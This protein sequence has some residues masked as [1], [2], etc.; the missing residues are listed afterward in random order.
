MKEIQQINQNSFKTLNR[1]FERFNDN[2]SVILAHC[3]HG[4]VKERI[5]KQLQHQHPNL[6]KSV[7]LDSEVINVYNALVQVIDAEPIP[8][9][10]LMISGLESNEQLDLLIKIMNQMREEFRRRFRCPLVFWVT[11]SLLHALIRLAP[12]FYSWSTALKFEISTEDLLNFIQETADQVSAKVLDSGAGIFLNNSYF[13]LEL[14][15]PLRFE[16]EAAYQELQKRGEPLNIELEASLEFVLGRVSEHSD[17]VA[18]KHYERSLELWQQTNNLIRY[19]QL[20]FYIGFWWHSYGILHRAEKEYAYEQA[21]S[22]YTQSIQ[23]FKR[24]NRWDLVAKFINALADVLFGLKKWQELETVAKESIYYNRIYTYPFREAR[25]YHFLAEVYLAKSCWQE[26]KNLAEKAQNLLV[27]TASNY[28]PKTSD[29]Q[30]ILDWETSYHQGWYLVAL[31]QANQKLKQSQDAIKILEKAQARTK[32]QY[33]PDL[34]IQILQLLHDFYFEKREYLK[35]YEIKQKRRE[36]EQQFRLRAF[37]GAGR[38]GH[39]QTISNP[40]LPPMKNEKIINPEITASGRLSVVNWLYERISRNDCKLTVIYGQSGVGKSSILQAG[41]IPELRKA[42]LDTR[43]FI[44]VLLQVYTNLNQDFSRAFTK[45]IRE[46]KNIDLDSSE[47]NSQAVI[48]EQIRSLVNQNFWV[49]II[50]DQFEEFFFACKDQQQRQSCY[51]FIKECLDIPYVKVVLSLREDYIQYLLECTRQGY[52]EII[53]NNILDR[54]ILAYIGNFTREEA[55]SVIQSLTERTQFVLES[56]LIEELVED[57]AEDSGDIRPIELQVVGSQLQAQR[58]TTL[59]QY[60]QAGRKQKLV[61]DYLDEVIRDCGSTNKSLAELVLYLLTD[62]NNTRPLKTR[63]DLVREIKELANHFE[64]INENLDTVLKIFVLSGLVFILPEIPAERY[65]LVHDYLV[66]L[67]RQNRSL[68]ILEELDIERKKRKQAE[69]KNK[70]LWQLFIR[71]IIIGSGMALLFTLALGFWRISEGKNKQVNLALENTKYTALTTENNQLEALLT[72][73]TAGKLLSPQRPKSAIEQ[74]TQSKLSL[75]VQVI[76]EQNILDGHQKNS[77]LSVSI[78]PDNQLIASA[79]DDKTI[80][81]W[82]PKGKC[83]KTLEG[84]QKSVWF[85]TFSPNSQI[86][87]SASKD[88][89]IKLWTKNGILIRTLQGHTDEVKWVSFSP[90]GQ[91]IASASKDKTVKIWSLDGRLIQTL[92]G[93]QKP[94]LSVVFSPDGQEIASSSEDGI[95]NLWTRQGKLIKTIKAHSKSIWSIS[96]SPDSQI[97]ASASDDKTV[98]LWNRD[99]Q[100]IR[101]LEGHQQAVNSVAFSQDSRLIATG[102]TD[103]MIKIWTKEGSLISTLQGH[104]D[105]IN[106]VSFS[107]QEERLFSASKDGTVRIW[108]LKT[109]PKIIQ[110]KDYKIYSSSFSRQNSNLVASPGRDLRIKDNTK[111][112]VVVLW[113]LNGEVQKIFRGH[114]DTVNNVSFSPDGKSIASASQDKTVR[115][116]SVDSEKFITLPH[117][118]PV[119]SVVFSPD[120]QLIATASDDQSIKI[121]DIHGTLKQTFKGHQG[122]INDLSFSPDSQILASASEDK[123]VKLWDV[124]HKNLIPPLTGAQ[125]R[126]N[127]VSF[128]PDGQWIAA[129]KDGESIA[130]W[131]KQNSA[132]K[133]LQTS[134]VLGKHWK[135]IYEV[136]FSPN[137]KILA[138]AS[139]D[140]TIKL[141]DVNGSLIT[142]LKPSLEPILSVNFSPDG[143]TLVGLQKS[144]PS[145]I[146]IWKIDTNQINQDTDSLLTQACIQLKDYLETNPNISGKNKNICDDFKSSP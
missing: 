31:A 83:I 64:N 129:S 65:Q 100:L 58:I 87:A 111:D 29:E 66:S 79:S 8:P 142:T 47:L 12:D 70:E 91:E 77:V 136:N 19:G 104:K 2:F 61:E 28:H 72:L 96:F 11:D 30:L 134:V 17:Q 39:I 139:A 27:Q 81:I 126:F 1:I 133:P 121:W 48:L 107:K 76:Q 26:A 93:H 88:N 69:A 105:S 21:N 145:R 49:V 52:L 97:M 116:W 24:A 127:S 90:D 71:S 43:R 14:G 110:L 138:S 86:I 57:L 102:S 141:W 99:G 60:Q 109:L 38:L 56:A 67:I 5:I 89:T 98:K 85:V 135:A 41:F 20:L 25:G 4:I 95:I 54:N 75:A 94:V 73:V 113:T 16:L 131:K 82:T 13:N 22:Y 123:T 33:D 51:Q 59:K 53:G 137:S 74:E 132:W 6:I 18:F 143:Q 55:K 128:S 92:K 44:P 112:D 50:F 146:S 118:S 130:I 35:A 34:Y 40:G 115:I 62:E 68:V 36:I 124:N 120:S 32:P 78:S 108:D 117:E 23:T 101:T 114:Q 10:G 125:I 103:E 119:W 106:Q 9:Q 45:G 63:A 42:S 140:G 80:K 84:H 15:S 122:A 7:V 37:I 46:V 144:E 3:N